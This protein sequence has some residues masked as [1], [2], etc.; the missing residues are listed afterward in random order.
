L[1][2]AYEERVAEVHDAIGPERLANLEVTAFRPY[3]D[4]SGFLIWV[5]RSFCDVI[6][7]DVGLRRPEA[8]RAEL[9][10]GQERIDDVSLEKIPLLDADVIFLALPLGDSGVFARGANEGLDDWVTALETS[11]LWAQLEAVQNQ[12]VFKV[13]TAVWNE[14]SVLAAHALLDDLEQYL[15]T[16]A[17]TT[18]ELPRQAVQMP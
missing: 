14:G 4:G 12:Q 11:P 16:P 5:D 7:A 1:L 13:D 9:P 15:G 18:D 10:A 2:A 3:T 8:Q 17:A 6:M